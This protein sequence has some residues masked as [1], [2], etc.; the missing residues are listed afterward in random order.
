MPITIEK[1]TE[2][3]TVRRLVPK[4]ASEYTVEEKCKLF[5]E[6]HAYALEDLEAFRS[7]EGYEEG[8]LKDYDHYAGEKLHELLGDGVF[9]VF[10]G[11]AE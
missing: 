2:T 6:L 4:A 7:G 11:E 8:G 10:N 5:D 3:K 9:D 1:K